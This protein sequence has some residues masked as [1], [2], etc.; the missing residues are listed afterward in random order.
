LGSGV[1]FV[2]SSTRSSCLMPNLSF[3]TRK[4]SSIFLSASSGTR[5]SKSIKS[6]Q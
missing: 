4:A 5:L 1:P 3:A 6:G 2:R